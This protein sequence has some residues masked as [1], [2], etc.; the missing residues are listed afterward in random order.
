MTRRKCKWAGPKCQRHAHFHKN[1]VEWIEGRP[2]VW[3]MIDL[4]NVDWAATLNLLSHRGYAVIQNSLSQ[5]ECREYAS[6]YSKDSLFRSTIDME[7]FRLGKGQY[8]YFSYPLPSS[9]EL[10]RENLYRQLAPIANDWSEKLSLKIDYP[11]SHPDFLQMCH[12]QGQ[13]RPTPLLLRYESGGFN[14][15]HQD[16]YGAVY[17]P[18][19]VVFMLTQKGLDHEGGEFVLTS[20]LPRAQSRVEIIT[21][22]QGDAVIFTTNFRPVKGS[23]G[24]YKA[25]V[26][27]G[28]AEVKFGERYAMGLIFHDGA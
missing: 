7:R 27:H 4:K 13:L 19:Q 20:Q 25:R 28:V 17:F 24:Y 22:G 26:K 16:L 10:M 9:I 14:T 23:K 5:E 6:H 3:T 12:K 11:S 18:F 1:R 2:L 8:K 15:L 21:A